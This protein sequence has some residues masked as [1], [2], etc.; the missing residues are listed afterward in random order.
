MIN[1]DQ[2]PPRISIVTPSYNQGAFLEA[3]IQSVLG[4]NYP[5]L[6]YVIIDG[7][8]TDDSVEIIRRYEADL[9]YWVS[10]PDEGQYD[11]INKGFGHTSG[12]I[13]AWINADDMFTPW[14]FSVVA[15]IFGQ[16]RNVEWLTSLLPLR[17][18]VAGRAVGC[19]PRR[20]YSR[21]SFLRG[22]H[23]PAVGGRGAEWLQQESTFWRRS[24][25]QRAGKLDAALD[26]ASDFKLWLQFCRAGAEIYG[27]ETPL[28]GFRKHDDQKTALRYEAYV[29]EATAVLHAMN[30][31]LRWPKWQMMRHTLLWQILP[32]RRWRQ[33][34]VR[35]GLLDP[36][37]RFVYDTK[38]QSWQKV[39]M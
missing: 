37:W 1:T 20:G 19:F 8:S 3:T 17:W 6:E 36:Y 24:L 29:A 35:L 11:A 28:G 4:Q 25:W 32:G 21:A 22:G 18:D 7:G 16:D 12:D 23:L 5:N 26:L 39:L 27:V 13:M 38:Q 30:G 2:S 14:A 15:E 33:T 34:A 10:E 31:K 9:A